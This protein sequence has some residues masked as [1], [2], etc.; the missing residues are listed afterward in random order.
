MQQF[1]E[2]VFHLG[3]KQTQWLSLAL[4][5]VLALSLRLILTKLILKK[6]KR[7]A[8]LFRFI[9]DWSLLLALI[10]AASNRVEGL[11]F[12][13]ATLFSFG[14]TPINI[15]GI[16]SALLFIM[17]ANQ[18]AEMLNQYLMQLLLLG[19]QNLLRC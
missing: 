8:P 10:Y 3:P 5:A 7:F 18:F 1:L 13:N 2:S 19:F 9:L 6:S 4:I 16:A 12:L 14:N 11:Q 17:L 15:F